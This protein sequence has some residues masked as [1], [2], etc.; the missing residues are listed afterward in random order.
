MFTFRREL[1]IPQGRIQHVSPIT[2]A[3]FTMIAQESPLRIEQD[4]QRIVFSVGSLR[5]VSGWNLLNGVDRGIVDVASDANGI[6][7]RFE[8]RYVR[9][10]LW[11]M[12]PIIISGLKLF[13]PSAIRIPALA[14]LLLTGLWL[15]SRVTLL[16]S[17]PSRF[18]KRI[19]A[20]SLS[21]IQIS[22]RKAISE[23]KET[24]SIG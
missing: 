16:S 12:L 21:A 6:N 1:T 17:L 19:L 15:F 9:T 7:L 22:S 2:R 4:K 5:T 11:S 20:V 23:K 24:K 18:S 14:I 3:I 13:W 8:L 10:A